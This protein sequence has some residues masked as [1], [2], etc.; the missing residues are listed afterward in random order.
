MG[1][2]TRDVSAITPRGHRGWHTVAE[3]DERGLGRVGATTVG[4]CGAT[5]VMALAS[6]FGLASAVRAAGGRE[7]AS[8]LV[9]VVPTVTST[10]AVGLVPWLGAH[11][12]I[13]VRTWAW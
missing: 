2:H 4:I 3:L 8:W 10:L 13:G 11:G 9:R 12:L 1:P 7:R 6:T 5:L